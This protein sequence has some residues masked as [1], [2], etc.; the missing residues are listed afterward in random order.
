MKR[1][2]SRRVFLAAATAGVAIG[3]EALAQNSAENTQEPDAKFSTDV[4]VVNVLV[5]VRDKQGKIVSELG[6]DDFEL[7]ED[8]H[9]QT[10]RYFTR[11]TNLPL[12]L[13]LLVD[14]SLSQRLVLDEERDASRR[15]VEKVLREDRDQ[16]FLIH[17]DHDT[18]LLQ[19]LT[20]SKN[21]LDHALD[22]LQLP[23]DAQSRG[24][25][26]GYPG[27]GG[28]YPGG[29]YPGGGGGYPGGGGGYPGGGGR[30]SNL[31]GTTLYDAVLLA[32]DELMKKQQGRK[33]FILLTDGVDNGSKVTLFRAIESAQR[34]DTLI[35]SI[36]FT[37][38][39]SQPQTFYP[40][41]F[42]G[43]RRGGFPMPSRQIYRPDGKKI[44]QQM[45]RETGGGFFEVSRKLSID[46]IYDR[47]EEELRNQY[48]LGYT[49]DRTDAGTAFRKIAVTIRQKNMI[50]QAR[51]GYYPSR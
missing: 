15:F 14:T 38:E 1:C 13:G 27:G 48:S 37:G 10:I 32:S 33:A 43:R 24:G 16:T 3:R 50:A 7:A 11:E 26:G 30:R 5:T 41:G 23:D 49:P 12:T 2:I 42:G 34:A 40:G 18:E 4:K 21:K 35:Y 28:G 29:G 31:P 46:D 22:N 8:G 9:P 51:E 36:Y 47:I 6:K 39:E 44:L 19:D 25:G 20:S 45:S 17:F